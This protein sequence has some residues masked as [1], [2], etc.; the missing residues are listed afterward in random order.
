MTGGTAYFGVSRPSI[1]PGRRVFRL[2]VFFLAFSGVSLFGESISPFV[3]P[4]ARFSGLGGNHVALA[5]DFYALFTNPAAF[6]EVE[7][8]FSVSELT[9]SSYGP[10]FEIL[11]LMINSSDSLEDLD[12]SGIIGEKGFAAG[13]DMGG[14][15]ALGWVGRGLGLGLFSRLKADAVVSGVNFRPNVSGEIL[16][17]GGYSFRVLNKN[18]HILDA[19]FLGK[20]FFRGGMDMDAP[21]VEVETL[22]DDP[23]SNKFKAV[24]GLGF[25]V[26]VKY[27]F[28]EKLSAALVCFDAYSPALISSYSSFKAFQDKE[29]PQNTYGTVNPRLDLGFTYRIR[30]EFLERYISN[31]S[32]L[33]DYRNFLDLFSLIPRN[34]ILNIGLGVEL[35]VL[36]ALSLRAGIADALPAVGFGLDLSF[37]KL[38]CSI[39]GKEL[40]L[41]PGVQSVYAVDMGL[42]FRY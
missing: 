33:A 42:L 2:A 1:F 35:V 19:G 39:Y 23:L 34:P 27:T 30:S 38:D 20:G 7:D 5:D 3:M 25:D 36:N 41:D 17:L 16:L 13:F 6:V 32:I 8:E 15:V 18:D 9:L 21:I 40:G 4:S 28:A 24:L 12:L 14:P 11:D 10:V 29:V 31:F 26:G 37:M 22:F